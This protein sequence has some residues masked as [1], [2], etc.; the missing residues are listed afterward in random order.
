MQTNATWNKDVEKSY[1]RDH[2][3]RR[4]NIW[5]TLIVHREH[6]RL[7]NDF[8]IALEEETAAPNLFREGVGLEIPCEVL[9]LLQIYLVQ[10]SCLLLGI[11]Q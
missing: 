4:R 5:L 1:M 3:M 11:R 9:N 10:Q 6:V 8:V 2:H 7:D